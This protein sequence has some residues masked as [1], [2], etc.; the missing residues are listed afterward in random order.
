MALARTATLVS[1]MVLVAIALP[2]SAATHTK[3]KNRSTATATLAW[4][5]LPYP[6]DATQLA[7]NFR[8]LDPKAVWQFF[9]S[10]KRGFEKGEF[11]TTE[12]FQQ[13][14]ANSS[15]ALSPLSAENEYAFFLKNV[16]PKYN[17]DSQTYE[18]SDY[19]FCKK[20]LGLGDDKGWVTCK[21]DSVKRERDSYVGTNSY[22]A[23]ARIERTVGKDLAIATQE[24]SDFLLSNAF[25]RNAYSQYASTF[26]LKSQFAVPLHKAKSL[27]Q[28]KLGLL[29][30]GKF[31]TAK[32]IDGRSVL[33]DPTVSEPTDIFITQDA[34]PFAPTRL[35]LFVIETGEIVADQRL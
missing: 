9:V 24:G 7:P 31:T 20:T 19:V 23:S 34:V 4:S 25:E 29:L 13:R 32:I 17:A 8:G 30:V 6:T 21:I 22:G 15:Q 33:I 12:Q 18:A 11:E 5:P 10:K 35:V 27:A 28:Y 26:D 16:T 2:L 3:A 14:L 1:L